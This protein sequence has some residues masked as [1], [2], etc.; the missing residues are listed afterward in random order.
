M[1]SSA[2]KVHF[3]P[4]GNRDQYPKLIETAGLGLHVQRGDF[5][6]IKT[7][8]G[9]RGCEGYISPKWVRPIAKAIRAARGRP[10]LTDTNT[11]YRGARSDAVGHLV[12]AMEH[13]F[14][15]TRLGLPIVIADGLRGTAFE[16]VTVDGD[17]FRTVK[18]AMDIA[19]ADGIVALSHVKGHLLCGF[20]G[21]VKNLGMGCGAKVG[22]YEMHAG[23]APSLN[24]K[25][26]TH[27][28]ACIAICPEWAVSFSGDVVTIDAARCV[29]CG[30][31]VAVCDYGCLN[32]PYNQSAQTLQER[33]AEY[34]YG[35]LKDRRS[36]FINFICHVTPNCD[37]IGRAEKPVTSDVGILASAD[38][39]AIDQASLDILNKHAGRDVFRTIW[40]DIDHTIQLTHAEKMGFGSRAYELVV[41]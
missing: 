38:P 15:Q 18:I 27:C 26:C 16:L 10:F 30:Q 35:A 17:H 34:A 22:K 12:V 4:W 39:V 21:A 36:F 5:T 33:I 37:C 7:H 29:G 20:G 19:R 23:T 32:I 14:S 6:A 8:F 1:S 24:L 13:G 25:A 28:G 9:E 40:P 41:L 2:S 31:C 11:I 3:L